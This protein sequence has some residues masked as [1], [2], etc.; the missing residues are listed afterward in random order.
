[1]RF[2]LTYFSQ[3]TRECA[4]KQQETNKPSWQ[5]SKVWDAEAGSKKQMHVRA[6]GPPPL[7]RAR[8][9]EEKAYKPQIPQ[10]TINIT[11]SE[12]DE[13]EPKYNSETEIEVN[14]LR[15][16]KRK[17]M[18]T[19]TTESSTYRA[20]VVVGDTSIH[21]RLNAALGKKIQKPN[22]PN[23]DNL[24]MEQMVRPVASVPCSRTFIPLH[25]S[26]TSKEKHKKSKKLQLR[27]I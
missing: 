14:S 27:F 2:G 22:K 26:Q 6:Y 17:E 4:L 12:V 10:S 13:D 7:P 16:E 8:T 18:T 5:E 21:A 24:S 20:A 19:A 11:D 15:N 23:V 1:M 25:N 9:N 3:T